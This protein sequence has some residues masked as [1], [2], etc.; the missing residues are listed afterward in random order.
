MVEQGLRIGLVQT[1]PQNLRKLTD[2][3]TAKASE[4]IEF[5]DVTEDSDEL[6]CL[7]ISINRG[8]ALVEAL[9]HI[10]R[11]D[12][13]CPI[14]VIDWAPTLEQA[15]TLSNV[16]NVHYHPADRVDFADSAERILEAAHLQRERQQK[17]TKSEFYDGIMETLPYPV[18]IKDRKAR[19][20][21]VSRS[22]REGLDVDPIGKTDAELWATDNGPAGEQSYADDLT[23]INENTEITERVEVSELSDGEKQW[24]L[25]SKH[26]WKT[27][28]E[29]K[30][31]VGITID[32]TEFK[33]ETELLRERAERLE[34]FASFVSHDLRNPITVAKGFLEE[35][36]SSN[37]TVHLERVDSA[38]DQ[39]ETVI[40][41]LL[42]MVLEDDEGEDL[43]AFRELAENAWRA[44]ETRT[45]TLANELPRDLEISASPGQLHQV[46]NNLFRNAVHHA[47]SDVT[48]RIGVLPGGFYVEDDGSGIPQEMRESILEY[49]HSESG[50]GIGLAIV[51]KIAE[52][53][54]WNIAVTESLDG[55][56]RFEFRDCLLRRQAFHAVKL[57]SNIALETANDVNDSQPSGDHDRTGQTVTMRGGGTDVY[58]EVDEHY[59]L[60]GTA[61]D[62]CRIQACLDAFHGVD[63]FSKAGVMIRAD[64]KGTGPLGFIGMT[65]DH[66]SEI[67]S[68]SQATELIVS[69]QFATESDLP[70]WYRIDRFP[71]SLRFVT[72][73]DG[74][75]WTTLKEMPF[76]V[77]GPIHLGLAVC[78]HD[79]E[80]LATATF[81]EHMAATLVPDN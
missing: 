52:N 39:M 34:Q 6:C 66:G 10:N 49:G 55:G 11:W 51:N 58:G 67:L 47:G 69:E 33:R 17:R 78:S 64:V 56:A 81:S 74:N 45:L 63:E 77:D 79:S 9:D 30:G 23:V 65:R 73:S 57:G 32:I 68:K 42:A 29:I 5:I 36:K 62:P 1:A 53:H 41:D 19:H 31:L 2:S 24:M 26:P 21:A 60:Y 14:F 54:G 16:A 38:L 40:D 37:D 20:I 15:T 8:I 75:E 35:A 18:Y 4:P 61:D 70:R 46:L 28:D 13:Q 27:G 76:P 22:H 48:V 7:L 43:V 25:T 50:T 12:A 44:C 3:I 59:F 71:H 80:T 72:S